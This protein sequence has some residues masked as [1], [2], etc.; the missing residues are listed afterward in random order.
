MFVKRDS[1]GRISA[2]SREP[3]AGFEE[4]LK[5]DSAELVAFLAAHGSGDAR[6]QQLTETDLELVRV[7]EDLVDLLIDRGVI[8]FTD[9]PEAAQEKL[10]K[11]QSLR[12]QHRGLNL[13]DDDF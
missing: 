5:P 11:R 8:T 12:L 13:L 2:V 10:S 3:L 7:I 1:E 4:E 9:L 6:Q